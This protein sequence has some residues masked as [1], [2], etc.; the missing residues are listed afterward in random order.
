MSLLG[1]EDTEGP[2]KAR[3]CEFCEEEDEMMIVELENPFY[4][5]PVQKVT[6]WLSQTPSN[7]LRPQGDTVCPVGS[8]TGQ[9]EGENPVVSPQEMRMQEAS[10]E[11]TTLQNVGSS[12][13][14]V[15]VHDTRRKRSLSEPENETTPKKKKARRKTKVP[16]PLAS[17]GEGL[18]VR[19]STPNER[20]IEEAERRI[21]EAHPS[22]PTTE[23]PQ[24][25]EKVSSQSSPLS[26]PQ[27]SDVDMY[28]RVKR[29]R[30]RKIPVSEFSEPVTPPERIIPS[31]KSPPSSSSTVVQYSMR[32]RSHPAS[33]HAIPSPKRPGLRSVRRG[34]GRVAKS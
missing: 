20:R 21:Q 26:I 22:S 33:V 16:K 6:A 30:R 31:S 11:S 7:L 1:H 24:E 23:H 27:D 25:A 32:E 34:G 4:L 2:L 3:E 28:S 8:Q 13:S 9:E 15:A 19:R 5:P 18:S 12:G 14:T 29:M 17:A 10:N